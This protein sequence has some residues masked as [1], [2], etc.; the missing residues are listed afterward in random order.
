M[1][2]KIMESAMK[3]LIKEL[4]RISYKVYTTIYT[5]KELAMLMAKL[6][7]N[8]NSQAVRLPKECRFKG[9]EVCV[10]K[11]KDGVLLSQKPRLAWEA[12]FSKHAPCPNFVLERPD[13]TL[14]QKRE[15]F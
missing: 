1:K 14:P 10:Q 2:S 3:F 15:L 13:N 11:T 4:D 5:I 8:G 7:R 6:F 12:F 9:N